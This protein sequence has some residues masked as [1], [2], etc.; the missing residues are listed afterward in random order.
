MENVRLLISEPIVV[1]WYHFCPH[2]LKDKSKNI[3]ILNLAELL[4]GHINISPVF[5]KG[6]GHKF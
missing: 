2:T 5:P 6:T 3:L 1:V 4:F